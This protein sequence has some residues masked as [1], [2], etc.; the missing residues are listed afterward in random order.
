MRGD[1]RTSEAN[2]SS[3]LTRSAAI[4]MSQWRR[5]FSLWWN[6]RRRIQ[7]LRPLGGT[8]VPSFLLA[9][10]LTFAMPMTLFLIPMAYVILDDLHIRLDALWAHFGPKS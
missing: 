1:L 4:S 5:L 8:L 2:P 7:P 6:A 9:W 10:G 3:T